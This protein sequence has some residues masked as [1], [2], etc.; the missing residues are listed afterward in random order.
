MLKREVPRAYRVE[1]WV[2][3]KERWRRWRRWR[4]CEGILNDVLV[5]VEQD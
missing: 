4:S 1:V 3:I 5:C 2:A